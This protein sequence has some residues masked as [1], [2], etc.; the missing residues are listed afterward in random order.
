MCLSL[1]STEM[2]TT[3]NDRRARAA[4]TAIL[5]VC[6]ALIGW[7]AAL[8]ASPSAL[9]VRYSRQGNVDRVR[10]ILS[11]GVDPNR[12]RGRTT[13]LLEAAQHGHLGVVQVLVQHGAKVDLCEAN[14]FVPRQS[15]LA[16]AAARG[17]VDVVEY[18]VHPD[19]NCNGSWPTPLAFAA[20]QGQTKAV[21]KLL[22][23]GADIRR[24]DEGENTYVMLAAWRDA[25]EAIPLL[26]AAGCELNAHNWS[27]RTA[28]MM[29]AD[30]RVVATLIEAGANPNL[31]NSDGQ[32]A[33]FHQVE[34]AIWLSQH[35]DSHPPFYNRESFEMLLRAGADPNL[36]DN[37]GHTPLE[38]SKR[39]GR[40]REEVAGKLLEYGAQQ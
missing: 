38:I 4:R 7:I 3:A 18:G 37:Q 35:P 20:E 23:L 31:R 22:Q 5:L 8:L 14:G 11:L 15:P 19:F 30:P 26:V 9:L 16:R 34:G 10:S 40:Y 17:H 12:H 39:A 21:A 25:P 36:P 29:S 33:L 1:V 24:K 13:P 28:L 6:V 27:G 2:S 32:T